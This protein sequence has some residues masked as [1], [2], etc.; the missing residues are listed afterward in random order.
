LTARFTDTRRCGRFEARR[1]PDENEIGL[2][3]RLAYLRN[4][5]GK[6]IAIDTKKRLAEEVEVGLR[7]M[8]DVLQAKKRRIDGQAL[9]N[10]WNRIKASYLSSSA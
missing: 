4:G 1:K 6:P 5:G 8:I 9:L 10:D 3:W 2:K 7:S